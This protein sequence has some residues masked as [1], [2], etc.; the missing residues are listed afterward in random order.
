MTST[1]NTNGSPTLPQAKGS[2]SGNPALE[3]P[4]AEANGRTTSSAD[5]RV[6]LTDSALALHQVAN[7]DRRSPVDTQRVEQIRKS[8]ADGSYQIDAGRIADRL[9]A[10]EGQLPGTP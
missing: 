2:Q 9:T 1:I 5:D 3:A 8:L 4:A 7:G 10:L 6:Q